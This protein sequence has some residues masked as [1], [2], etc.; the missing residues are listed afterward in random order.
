MIPNYQDNPNQ[1]LGLP[2]F[3]LGL[4]GENRGETNP[5]NKRRCNQH[6]RLNLSVGLRLTGNR[7]HG[8]SAD[9]PDT[10]TGTDYGEA[11]SYYTWNFHKIIIKELNNSTT[12]APLRVRQFRFFPMA[13][14]VLLGGKAEIERCQHGEDI[15]LQ[16]GH[17]HLDQRDGEAQSE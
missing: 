2:W 15:G 7:F 17:Q 6:R 3:W 8:T 10:D 11:C 12:K 14:V 16:Q 13:V 9:H 5:F 4:A 1:P